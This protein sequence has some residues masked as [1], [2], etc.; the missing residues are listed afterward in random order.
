M[1]FW[2]RILMR[3][4]G[5]NVKIS[6]QQFGFAAGKSTTDAIFIARQ[7]QE[8]SLQNKKELYHIFVDLEKAFDKVPRQAISWALRSQLVPEYLVKAAVSL[9]TNSSSRI[10]FAGGL[11]EKFPIRVGVHQG[12][13]LIPLLFKIVMEEATKEVQVG[14]PWEL[15]YADDL[16]LSADSNESVTKIFK[17]WSSAVELRGMK[18]N[19][20]KTKLLISGKRSREATSSVQNPGAVC[21][22]GVGVNSIFCTSCSKWCHKR[23]TG[24]NSLAGINGY[25]CPVCSG[26]QQ[27]RTWTDDSIILDSGKVEEVSEF[28]YLGGH[29]AL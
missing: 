3:R 1:N 5:D 29:A 12:S 11:S 14:E 17:D 7:L 20:G 21:N 8:K 27:P 19:I 24:L 2:E 16:V 10:R 25:T 23:C 15:L 4:L 13:A 6:P 28:C 26:T 9:Y 18:V 22:R